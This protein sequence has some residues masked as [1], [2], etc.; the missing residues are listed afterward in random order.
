MTAKCYQSQLY[1]VETYVVGKKYVLE[2]C[3]ISLAE[4]PRN[5]KK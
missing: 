2:K 4:F 5:L 1:N 3:F